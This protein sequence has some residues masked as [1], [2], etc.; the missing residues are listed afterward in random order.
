VKLKF[1]LLGIAGSL[2]ILLIFYFSWLPDPDIGLKPYFPGWLGQW[3]NKNPNLRTAVPFVFVGFVSELLL[4]NHYSAWFKR[5]LLF[6]GLTIIVTFAELGQLLLPLRHFDI[7]D[8]A[9]GALG[10]AL[11]IVSGFLIKK[12]KYR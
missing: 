8:I 5:T 10:S 7:R 12:L 3:T 9:W 6:L 11:G 2:G 4:N 1:V